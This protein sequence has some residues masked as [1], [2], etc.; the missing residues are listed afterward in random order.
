[1]NFADFKKNASKMKESLHKLAQ[2]PKNSYDDDRF[3]TLTKDKIGN[4]LATIRFLPQQDPSDSPIILTFRHAFQKDGRWFIDECPHTIGEKCPICE[5]SSSIWNT[6][7]DEARMY[8]RTKGYIANILVVKDPAKPENDGKVF[9]FK[10]GKKIYDKIMNIVAPEEEDEE[11]VNI[12]DF[13]AG[14]DFKLKLGQVAG[15]N[16]YDKSSFV[17]KQT[18]VG[19]G[20]LKEQEAIFNAIHKLDEFVDPERFKTYDQL[21]KKLTKANAA[22]AVPSIDSEIKTDKKDESVAFEPDA[23]EEEVTDNVDDIDFDALLS[24]ED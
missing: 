5:Y 19:G 8:W 15:Y 22:V 2:E 4:G 17:F 14:L 6:N 20:K 21:L 12:F 9:M 11:P 23:V 18:K 16:N 1:M 13:D 10:F 7:E 24:D 3:W